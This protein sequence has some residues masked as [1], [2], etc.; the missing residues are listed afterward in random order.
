MKE[1]FNRLDLDM[2]LLIIALG[3]YGMIYLVTDIIDFV[4]WELLH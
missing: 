1:W 3:L 4:A 2:K